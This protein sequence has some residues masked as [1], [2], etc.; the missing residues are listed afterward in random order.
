MLLGVGGIYTILQ[1]LI[2]AS[3]IQS[4]PALRISYNRRTFHSSKIY[5]TLWNKWNF[6]FKKKSKYNCATDIFILSPVSHHW[7]RCCGRLLLGLMQVKHDV[8]Y[9]RRFCL[10]VIFNTMVFLHQRACNPLF[11]NSLVMLL[12]KR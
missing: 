3:C 12:N 4:Y 10:T 11:P 1:G 6:L 5:V 9:Q 8:L 2:L 7:L